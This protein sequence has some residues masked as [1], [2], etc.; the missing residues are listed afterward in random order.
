MKGLLLTA[1]AWAVA[2]CV[3]SLP[4]YESQ[5]HVVQP[6]DTLYTIAWRHGLDYRDLARWNGLSNPDLIFVG[7]RIRLVPAGGASGVGGYRARTAPASAPRAEPARPPARPVSA[8]PSSAPAPAPEAP[9]PVW[10]WPTEGAV[11]S[12]FG[13][14]E[15]VGS[16][17]D[18][19]G[20]LGQPVVAAAD[21]QVVYAGSGLIGYGQL[22]IIK[23]NDT[24]LSAYGYNSRLT[25]EQGTTVRQGQKI[26]EMGTAAGRQPLLH[27]EIR[28]NGTPIDPLMQ[29]ASAR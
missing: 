18:I 13:A 23:H 9:R 4:I 14:A 15:G 16:G 20:R 26:A 27:F 6:G 21:G 8:P 19:G 28:R 29:L 5:L 1:C 22:V 24:Y 3:S 2:G 17:I 7:Q 10:R 12:G 25:V 11:V